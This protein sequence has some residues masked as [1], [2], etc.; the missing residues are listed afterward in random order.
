MIIF[1]KQINLFGDDLMNKTRMISGQA[2][3]FDGL[4]ALGAPLVTYPTDSLLTTSG[5]GFDDCSSCSALSCRIRIKD[6]Y[7][8]YAPLGNPFPCTTIKN[9]PKNYQCQFINNTLADHRA[10]DGRPSPCCMQCENRCDH[11][12]E[13]S[14]NKG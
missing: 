13:R 2:S 9:V 12:C 7:C 3:L 8:R 4:S 14:I 1:K 10:G 11:N 6:R 5:C